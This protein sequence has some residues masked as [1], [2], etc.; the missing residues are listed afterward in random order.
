[1]RF[2][3]IFAFILIIIQVFGYD[4]SRGETAAIQ[5][6]DICIYSASEIVGSRLKQN[7]TINSET[8][9]HEKTNIGILE[10][11]YTNSMDVVVNLSPGNIT[12]LKPMNLTYRVS[13]VNSDQK[14][15]EVTKEF[16][17]S[18]CRR[19]DV[20][21][22]SDMDW[23]VPVSVILAVFAAALIGVVLFMWSRMRRSTHKPRDPEL[24]KVELTEQDNRLV[25]NPQQYHRTG[26]ILTCA[27]RM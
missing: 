9:T 23:I 21:E 13:F 6:Q 20:P 15:E 12:L 1:M 25:Q 3:H 7:K 11:N 18:D 17:T 14:L 8:W 19:G 2:K 5:S 22:H 10:S 27:T 4:C 16:K 24:L 26:C